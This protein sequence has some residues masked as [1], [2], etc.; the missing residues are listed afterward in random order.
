[1]LTEIINDNY[2]RLRRFADEI[3]R[4]VCKLQRPI[5]EGHLAN[6]RTEINSNITLHWSWNLS[7]LQRNFTRICAAIAEGKP[8][9]VINLSSRQLKPAKTEVLERRMK[10]ANYSAFHDNLESILRNSSI[11]EEVRTSIRIIWSHTRRTPASKS[12]PTRSYRSFRLNV[13][14]ISPSYRVINPGRLSCFTHTEPQSSNNFNAP[15][16][17]MFSLLT[18]RQSSSFPPW[19]DFWWRRSYDKPRR[20][21]YLRRKL[22]SLMLTAF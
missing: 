12:Q 10:D 6:I 4:T 3:D 20:A 21:R 8:F 13:I 5:S 18:P 7:R 17:I 22:Q 2:N 19:I 11:P 15:H 9:K 16:R 14:A 1:M